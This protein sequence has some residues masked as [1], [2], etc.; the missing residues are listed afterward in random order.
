MKA[1]EL[2]KYLKLPNPEV[3][4]EY[5][6]VGQ[7]YDPT[8]HDSVWAWFL[9]L[10]TAEPVKHQEIERK[11]TTMYRLKTD[12]GKEWLVYHESLYGH[13]WKGNRKDFFNSG[14]GK[15]QG[16]PIWEY[17]RDPSTNKVVEGTTQ[18]Q[19]LEDK[20]TIP[21]SKD[22]VEKL[23]KY[24]TNKTQYSIDAGNRRYSCTLEEFKDLPYKQ[25]VDEK[26]GMFEY[27]KNRQKGEGMYK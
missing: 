26:T 10:M 3:V 5:Q 8:V 9:S 7:V 27:F 15:I 1:Y 6:R 23:L 25:L 17:E 20:Y 2:D 16:W 24:T 13:D 11:I 4:A 22:T 18:V 12:D 21:F 19:A 14:V